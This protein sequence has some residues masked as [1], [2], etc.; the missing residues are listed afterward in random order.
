MDGNA[1]KRI[2]PS[3][4]IDPPTT[5]IYHTMADEAGDE[6]MLS[7]PWNT[8]LFSPGGR[9]IRPARRTP[10]GKWSWTPGRLREV[11]TPRPPAS[12]GVVSGIDGVAID[13]E[14][15]DDIVVVYWLWLM[16][17]GLGLFV[18]GGLG[19][20]APPSEHIVS[21]IISDLYV[22]FFGVLLVGAAFLS[23]ATPNEDFAFIRKPFWQL[24]LIFISVNHAWGCA[25]SLR[26]SDMDLDPAWW[27]GALTAFIM[28]GLLFYTLK[29]WCVADPDN[30]Q[31]AG[32]SVSRT[33][34]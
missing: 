17:S 33:L 22:I 32:P 10:P 16:L 6:E 24:L 28:D 2:P 3:K 1:S 7:P 4:R 5:H 8:K 21:S 26:V 18:A 20:H 14:A 29:K 31:R 19:I 30:G 34:F 27:V 15:N 13:D 12:Q 23:S 25:S 11:P 9:K